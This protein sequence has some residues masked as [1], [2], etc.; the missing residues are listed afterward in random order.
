MYRDAGAT[1]REMPSGEQARD[2]AWC[3]AREP[4]S[5]Q[6]LRIIFAQL[7]LRHCSSFLQLGES[8]DLILLSVLWVFCLSSL[9]PSGVQPVF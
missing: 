3:Y 1:V 2:G 8:Q 7:L 6:A 4:C 5:S 9:P